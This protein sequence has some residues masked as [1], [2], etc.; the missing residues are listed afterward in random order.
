M[1]IHAIRVCVFMRA[2]QTSSISSSTL[3][4]VPGLVRA[5]HDASRAG[6]VVSAGPRVRIRCVCTYTFLRARWMRAGMRVRYHCINRAS[7][8]PAPRGTPRIHVNRNNDDT[9]YRGHISTIIRPFCLR[10]TL[11]SYALE[12]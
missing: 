4:W 12:Y 3:G 10:A 9:I 1:P 5:S 11:L 7:G 8:Q 2:A 6:H